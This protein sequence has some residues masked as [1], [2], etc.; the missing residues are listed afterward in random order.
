VLHDSFLDFCYP[1]DPFRQP[2]GLQ[3]ASRLLTGTLYMI[4]PTRSPSAPTRMRA[5]SPINLYSVLESD[6]DS[7]GKQTAQTLSYSQHKEES[8]DKSTSTVKEHA[9]DVV[10]EP[11]ALIASAKSVGEGTQI[12]IQ[13]LVDTH[14]PEQPY[15]VNIVTSF[16][17][18]NEASTLINAINVIQR[19][20]PTYQHLY[21]LVHSFLCSSPLKLV[22]VSVTPDR[23]QTPLSLIDIAAHIHF[24]PTLLN[25][26]NIT[27]ILNSPCTPQA[28]HALVHATLHPL[29]SPPDHKA[30][31]QAV[32]NPTHT[33]PASTQ[34]AICNLL[35]HH[36]G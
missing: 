20:S 33:L 27:P 31:T 35:A 18:D 1:Q 10:E 23:S 29:M 16:L 8:N 36:H 24:N 21:N 15:A 5:D 14:L 4:P 28:R 32:L 30:L 26:S 22:S 3:S 11:F 7:P 13:D 17:S 2:C 9:M 25:T 12:S 34:S 19:D 6:S